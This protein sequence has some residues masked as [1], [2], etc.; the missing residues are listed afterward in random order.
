M[1]PQGCVGVEG[2]QLA[3]GARESHIA[4]LQ[5]R[6]RNGPNDPSFSCLFFSPQ[7]LIERKRRGKEDIILSIPVSWIKSSKAHNQGSA[8]TNPVDMQA[9]RQAKKNGISE[10][11]T[12]NLQFSWIDVGQFPGA[13]KNHDNYSSRYVL[14]C[15]FVHVGLSVDMYG[16]QVCSHQHGHTHNL[17]GEGQCKSIM[18]FEKA[19]TS[20]RRKHTPRTAGPRVG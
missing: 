7:G 13:L 3:N 14:P 2:L 11:R 15:V 10:A 4:R 8:V 1:D 18:A 9:T 6:H 20:Q 19:N 17:L 16:K 5:P 12:L